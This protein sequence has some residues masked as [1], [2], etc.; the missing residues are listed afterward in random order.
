MAETLSRSSSANCVSCS[1]LSDYQLR[2]IISSRSAN[3]S[4]RSLTQYNPGGCTGV[5]G[6]QRPGAK[7]INPVQDSVPLR[8]TDVQQI[9]DGHHARR[10]NFADINVMCIDRQVSDFSRKQPCLPHLGSSSIRTALGPLFT[11]CRYSFGKLE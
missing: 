6:L 8:R 1:L 9:Q 4:L 10:R 7:V 5:N 3:P 2:D 11:S